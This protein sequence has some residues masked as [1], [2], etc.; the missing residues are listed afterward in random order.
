MKKYF[1]Y[2]VFIFVGAALMQGF[3]CASTNMRTAD[4]HFEKRRYDKA[5][6]YY[7]KELKTNPNNGRAWIKLVET[8]L[9]L[10]D[11][12]GAA[13][14][15]QKGEE[16]ITDP[17]TKKKVPEY[18]YKLWVSSYNSGINYYN[19]YLSTKDE[20]LIDSSIT[21]FDIAI[22][23][24]PG[25][26]DFYNLKGLAYEAKGD[27]KKAMSEYEDYLKVLDDEIQFASDHGVFI[28][29]T[30]EKVQNRLGKPLESKGTKP[31]NAS[32]S[33]ITD[34][35]KIDEKDVYVFYSQKKPD[36]ARVKGWKYDP[37]ESWTDSEREQW[38]SLSS[39]PIASLVQSYYSNKMYDKA[40]DG[41]KK[42]LILEPT[43]TQANTFMIQLYQEQGKMDEAYKT[44]EG[45]MK[46]DPDNKFYK[47]QYADLLLS[48]ENIDKAIDYYKQALK[49]DPEFHLVHRNL[50]SALKNKAGMIQK[51]QQEKVE[52]DD[53]Y[54]PDT[55]EYFPILRE[56]AN[57]FAKCRKS[58]R[59]ED[60]IEVL[61]ELVNIYEVLDNKDKMNVY[62][63]ELEQQEY[64]TEDKE[65]YYQLMCKLYT[66]LKKTEKARE[67]CKQFEDLL[68]E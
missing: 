44:L 31:Q 24:R 57:Y 33:S 23:V 61:S 11:I 62:L 63:E 55:E 54:I 38:I 49:I 12:K 13:E 19:Q 21:M 3:Q 56:S 25:M 60:D 32:D 39:V 37:P 6:E 48:K 64:I 45:M 41:V 36:M 10:D 51:A 18:K 59:F 68:K 8:H 65:L 5:K 66:R 7:Q 46:K 1:Y 58:D 26:A 16:M 22:L 28:D 43:N 20:N 53:S 15:I 35:Y 30:R 29:Q 14:T 17:E 9:R 47:A 2:L 50:A 42:M 52:K 40:L 67:A 4:L 27:D 34:I